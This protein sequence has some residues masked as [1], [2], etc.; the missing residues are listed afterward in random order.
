[1]GGIYGPPDSSDRFAYGVFND[2]FLKIK[3]TMQLYGTQII[4]LAGDWNLHLDREDVKP[5]TCKLVRE[6]IEELGMIDVGEK[7]RK[8]TWTRPGRRR[9]KSRIDY[10]MVTE[11]VYE[12]KL[13]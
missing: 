5:R 9:A 6:Y 10:V 2:F 7:E 1:M 13:A 4:V 3:E 11:N 8:F 12:Y